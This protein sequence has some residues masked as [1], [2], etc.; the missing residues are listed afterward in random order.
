MEEVDEFKVITEQERFRE[1]KKII[2]KHR[3]IED[4]LQSK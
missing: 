3:H 2:E 1:K 4:S